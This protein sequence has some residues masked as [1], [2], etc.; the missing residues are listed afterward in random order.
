MLKIAPSLIS[1][2]LANLAAE[3][4][5]LESWQATML[6][7]DVMDGL[8]V[9]NLSFGLP[10]LRA[11]RPITKL[12]L[13]VHLMIVQPERYIA[14][15]AEAG[16][17]IIT[18]HQEAT[19]HLH[20]V[21]TMIKEKGLKA[22]VALNPATPLW[23][24]NDVISLVD[25][26]ILM[27]VNPGFGGSKFIESTFDKVKELKEIITKRQLTVAIEIDGGVNAD[28]AAALQ[29]AGADILVAGTAIFKAEDPQTM[30]L[31]LAN[32]CGSKQD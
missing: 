30:I 28:N 4:K 21:I 9:P 22:G 5:R 8:Y 17:D 12:P 27:A 32:S 19:V 2:D 11:I 1:A 15:F 20:R 26:V 6:H 10:L 29:K 31:R 14:E 18:V 24:L 3:I 16:A 7:Y 13:D 25:V 23:V